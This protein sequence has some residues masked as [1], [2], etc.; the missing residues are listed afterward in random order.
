MAFPVLE[1]WCGTRSRDETGDGAGG[2]RNGR[3][4]DERAP[5]PA[6]HSPVDPDA[7]LAA[8]IRARDGNALTQLMRAYSPELL[9]FAHSYVKTSVAA[10]DIVQDVFVSLWEL[11]DKW[12]V[13]GTVR[14]YLFASV[15]NRAINMHKHDV[16]MQAFEYRAIADNMNPALGEAPV[17]AD[18]QL[19]H[20]E[21]RALLTRA[22]AALPLRWKQAVMLRIQEQFS[23]E[24]IA[25]AL[26]ISPGAARKLVERAQREL[27]R[28]LLPYLEST[29]TE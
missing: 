8:Q 11:G 18:Q 28:L 10:N 25:I 7:L 9:R 27:R 19:V 15:R 24:E 5:H 26:G 17:P 22:V 12:L 14:A 6:H 23:Y 21:Q 20:E 1:L 2:Q 4:D 13:T 3:L 29:H 16:R